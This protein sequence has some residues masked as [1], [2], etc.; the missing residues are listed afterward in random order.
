MLQCCSEQS[1]SAKSL[2]KARGVSSRIECVNKCFSSS[3]EH[4]DRYVATTA[5]LN[6]SF[7]GH[8]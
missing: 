1:F 5:T 6:I 2:G 7:A 4:C 8:I 3:S